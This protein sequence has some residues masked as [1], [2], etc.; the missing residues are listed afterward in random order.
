MA[1]TLAISQSIASISQVRAQFG[2]VVDPSPL[3]F[4][5]WSVGLP[6]LTATDAPP[7]RHR[8]ATANHRAKPIILL[9]HLL[10]CIGHH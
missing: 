4:P 8:C 6:E 3:F 10:A 9:E 5:E 7:M 1:Q 2:L